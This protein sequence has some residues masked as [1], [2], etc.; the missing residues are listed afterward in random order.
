MKNVI[1][2]LLTN[3]IYTNIILFLCVILL[4]SRIIFIIFNPEREK[5]FGLFMS[6]YLLVLMVASWFIFIVLLEFD[7]SRA[8]QIILNIIFILTFIY[9]LWDTKQEYNYMRNA[10]E[11]KKFTKQTKK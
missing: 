5:G 7:I 1:E 4:L 3:H 9:L 11:R 8:N 10:K 2:N 6:I